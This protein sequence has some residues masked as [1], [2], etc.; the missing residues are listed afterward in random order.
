M[1]FI[2]SVLCHDR[3]REQ[4]PNINHK[5]GEVERTRQGVE[6]IVSGAEVDEQEGQDGI[7]YNT[8]KVVPS[9]QER[10]YPGVVVT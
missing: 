9:S 6:L 5:D 1:I 2:R 4:P 7:G 10:E 8:H 3:R